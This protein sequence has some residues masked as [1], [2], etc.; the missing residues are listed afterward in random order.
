M[1]KIQVPDL[2]LIIF[3]HLGVEP[4]STLIKSIEGVNWIP[5]LWNTYI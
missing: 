2:I 3:V 5:S 1:K 4:S